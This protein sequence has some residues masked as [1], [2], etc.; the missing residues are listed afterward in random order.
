MLLQ[1]NLHVLSNM[2]IYGMLYMILWNINL[3]IINTSIAL[4]Y[5]KWSLISNTSVAQL[6]ARWNQRLVGTLRN[7]T[8]THH[9]S[10]YPH[11]WS[12]FRSYFRQQTIN[13]HYMFESAPKTFVLQWGI[14]VHVWVEYGYVMLLLRIYTC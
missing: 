5:H 11:Q 7:K 10:A 6:L 1:D 14:L 3:H 13:Y 8:V 4:K 9:W 12:V 2:C